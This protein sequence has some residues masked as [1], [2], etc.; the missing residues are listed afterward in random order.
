MHLSKYSLVEKL[1]NSYTGIEI[2]AD[3]KQGKMVYQHLP[4]SISLSVYLPASLPACLSSTHI[5]DV[6]K[7]QKISFLQT[8]G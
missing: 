8:V 5:L 7:G 1:M 2:I 6:M 4:L 3:E